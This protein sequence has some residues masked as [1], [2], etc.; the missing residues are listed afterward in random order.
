LVG[1]KRR[2]EPY[3]G[4]R[5]IPDGNINSVFQKANND[6]SSFC[7]QDFIECEVQMLSKLCKA[8][9]DYEKHVL[10]KPYPPLRKV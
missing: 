8:V 1:T 10:A 4:I 5:V 3:Q 6:A 2:N 7:R 9:R